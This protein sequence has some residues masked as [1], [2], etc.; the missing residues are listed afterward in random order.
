M[1]VTPTKGSCT[2][3]MALQVE[4]GTFANVTL[5]GL[6]FIVLAYTP[7]AMIKGNWSVGLIIDE[8]AKAEQRD[9][10]AA[11]TS[12]NAGG[13]MAA[14]SGLVGKFAGI[15]SARIEFKRNGVKWTVNASP[16]LEMSAEGA[17]GIN[18]NNPEP[19][20]LD[21]TGHPINDR[22]ALCHAT[23]SHVKALGI[24][25]DDAT[26]KNNG[27]YAPFSWRSA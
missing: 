1:A 2:F 12:G 4:R 16:L 21:N 6:G 10:I 22:L 24:S 23:K 25:W 8:R 15:E 7:E 5:D 11:I 18:P 17:M 20:Y 14:L 9:A 3:A 26:G 13:P 27:H 19:L